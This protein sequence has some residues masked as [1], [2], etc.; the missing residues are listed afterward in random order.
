MYQNYL[1]NLTKK[2]QEKIIWNAISAYLLIFI[3]ILFLRNKKNKYINNPFVKNHTKS[4]FFI[5]IC[6][7]ITYII[8]ISSSVFSSFSLYNIQLNNI[9]ASSLSIFLLFILI[10]WIYKAKSKSTFN[11][12]EIIKILRYDSHSL[13]EWEHNIIDI[14]WDNK[15]DEKDKL[16]III[17]YIPFIWYFN[18]AKYRKNETI[19][20]ATKLNLIISIIITLLYISWH[21]NLANLLSLIYIIFITFI[22][23]NLF[24][25]ENLI[26][27]NLKMIPSPEKKYIIIISI[28]KY[29]KSYFKDENLKT[30]KEVINEVKKDKQ[31][32]ELKNEENLNTLENSSWKKY[33]KDL[34][35]PKFLIYIP[36]INLIFLFFKKSKYKFHIINGLI[37]TILIIINIITYSYFNIRYNLNILFLFPII[38]WIWYLKERI[39]YK[40]PFIYDFYDFFTLIFWK[41]KDF[42][43]KY[44]K[45]IEVNL[46]VWEK[47]NT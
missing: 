46:K 17:S 30:L 42:N 20:N 19:Q 41:T 37:L 2:E 43:K 34:I 47:E 22:W 5:H 18:F 45:T 38:F 21:S 7:L 3:S 26:N 11:I 35:L 39:A 13:N 28:F 8:F 16:T 15:F 12:W 40:M 6:F 31:E 23:I 27:I 32:I 1:E 25:N 10:Y 44:N 14:N 33:Y 9:I 29:L 24:T 4:A 36:F